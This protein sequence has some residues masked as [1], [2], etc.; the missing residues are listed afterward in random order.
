MSRKD[1]KAEHDYSKSKGNQASSLWKISKGLK[2]AQEQVKRN[3]D[4]I[5]MR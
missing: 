1:F 4:K 5:N 2:K 3:K